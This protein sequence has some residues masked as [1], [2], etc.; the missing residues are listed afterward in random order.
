[1]RIADTHAVNNL[2]ELELPSEQITINEFFKKC[3]L[4]LWNEGES[5]SGKRPLGDS[6]WDWDVFAAL[7][8]GG[9]IDAEFDDDGYLVDCDWTKGQDLIEQYIVSIFQ[10]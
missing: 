8:H 7:G 3:L 4:N 2:G 5:F 1:V 6:G 9:F 10:G